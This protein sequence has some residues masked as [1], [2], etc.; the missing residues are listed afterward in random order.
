MSAQTLIK[1]MRPPFLLLTPICIYL[2]ASYVHYQKIPIDSALL[3]LI[4]LGATSAH[5]SVNMLNE[6]FDF[7]SGIDLQTVKTPFSGGSG[8]L[9]AN[10]RM[11]N[12]VLY[13]GI[14]SLVT[15]MTIGGYFI[16][17]QGSSIIPVGI[18]GILVI[19]SYTQW[20]NRLP[21]LCLVSPGL[22]FGMLMVT[23]TVLVLAGNMTTAIWGIVLCP[24]F[25]VN[26]LLLLN[27]LP[28][29]DAD[30]AGGRNHFPI[31]YGARASA[32]VYLLFAVL[33]YASIVS[34]TVFNLLPA[35]ALISLI[36]MPLSLYCFLGAYRYG[37]TIG[38]HSQYLAVNVII[39]LLT[40][41]LLGTSLLLA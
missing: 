3:L 4:V 11:A 20:L 18:L 25:L 5:I 27:Q 29:I 39:S 16:Y 30:Q 12:F 38:S 10:P 28:D 23:G 32:M 1:T 36:T 22:G 14:I 15:T 9:P 34:A 24:F 31:V 2:G 41:A 7:T 26:N 37:K 21:L 8:A 13:G 17:L 19:T 6:Y 33:A 40:P 35:W